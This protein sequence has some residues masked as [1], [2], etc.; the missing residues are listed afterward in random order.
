MHRSMMMTAVV[1]IVISSTLSANDLPTAKPDEVGM[2]AE[3]LADIAPAMQ[4]FVDNGTLPGVITLIA[5]KGKVV[6][7]DCVGWRDVETRKPMQRDTICRIYSQSKPV[8]GVAVMILYEEGKFQLDDPVSKYLPEF[9]NLKVL[10]D[11]QKNRR[12]LAK[13]SNFSSRMDEATCQ[14]AI[15]HA[16]GH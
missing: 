15:G 16:A 11:P 14:T 6:Y 9:T 10:L 7:F 4:K 1:I 3:C 5:R 12:V 13:P 2:S 8:T